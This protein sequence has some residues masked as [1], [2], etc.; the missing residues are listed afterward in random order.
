MYHQ[1]SLTDLSGTELIPQAIIE[2]SAAVLADYLRIK[3]DTGH[4]ELD[5]FEAAS[6]TID[7]GP[8]FM[9]KHYHGY[10]IDT[11]AIYLSH[12]ISKLDQISDA[13]RLIAD[14]LRIPNSSIVWQR[15]DDPDL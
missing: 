3:L 14:A 7:R 13:I 6:L 15:A 10:P 11:T 5:E 2:R 9:L 8:S 12:E 4:D 1:I